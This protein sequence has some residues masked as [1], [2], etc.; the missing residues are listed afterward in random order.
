MVP[1]ETARL[2]DIATLRATRLPVVMPSAGTARLL[3]SALDLA[4][5]GT[6][7]PPELVAWSGWVVRCFD[8]ARLAGDGTAEF[9]LGAE[10]ELALWQRV[11]A[12]EDAPTQAAPLARDA[13][14]LAHAWRLSWSDAAPQNEDSLAFRRWARAYR[15]YTAELGATD[16]ARVPELLAAPVAGTALAHGFIAPA[17]ATAAW[18]GPGGSAPTA[19]P[20]TFRGVAYA[21][22]ASE[23]D[24][25]LAW[26]LERAQAE[27]A[28]RVVI[29]L[30]QLT[31]ERALVKRALRET[32][33]LAPA[34][35]VHTAVP[36]T[37]HSLPVMQSALAVIALEP[38][39]R[40][41][42]L[43]AV[44]L[45]PHTLGAA[46]EY[47]ARAAF[48]AGLR[49]GGHYERP[50]ADV[51]TLAAAAAGV[52]QL[53]RL[54]AA[55][56][57]AQAQAPRRQTLNGWRAHFES[58]LDAAGWPGELADARAARAAWIETGDRLQRLDTVLPAV[59][60]GEARA[61][62]RQLLEDTAVPQ[63]GGAAGIHLVTPEI[64]LALAPDHLWL[65]GAEVD[66]FNAPG[67]P[68]PLWSYAAQRAAGVPGADPARDLARAQYLVA[69]LAHGGGSRVASYCAGDGE[70]T[71][72]PSPLIPALA[73]LTAVPAR[74]AAPASWLPAEVTVENS[75]DSCGTPLTDPG[76]PLAGGVGALAAQAACPFR[77][78]ARHR[79]AA[80]A[81][82][83]PRPG[84]EA[85]VRGTFVHRVLA[86]VWSQLNSH[87]ALVALAP[88]E[89]TALLDSAIG[90]A[91]AD[92]Q[93]ATPLE[94]ALAALERTRLAAVVRAWLEFE[95]ARPPFTVRA[96]EQPAT[97]VYGGLTLRTRIDRLDRLADGR[98]RIV[99]YKT[100][101]C[102]A[103]AWQP[104][105][106]DEP[107]LPFYALTNPSRALA[108]IAFAKVAAREPGWIELPPA[109]TDAEQAA[110]IWQATCAAWADDLAVLADQLRRGVATVDPKRGGQTCRYCELSL[111]CRI[112]EAVDD[113]AE[114]DAADGEP[115]DAGMRAEPPS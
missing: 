68:S 1:A 47:A 62:L 60:R 7:E 29:A 114:R 31:R 21:D 71:F 89:L 34:L 8:A 80:T 15:A 37:L 93:F 17:P 112:A 13:W 103:S 102:R 87:A 96:V 30:P 106:L 41:D 113:G 65:A 32:L 97:V 111:L 56:V 57:A 74:R 53:A 64:A 18:L 82:D 50:L 45:S 5:G 75:I 100:G 79:L 90:R 11:L 10:Q 59:G 72:S 78:Y 22:R 23:L 85:K 26:A 94:R 12:A 14:R 52:P 3:Q 83:E 70:Q 58:C 69:L 66:A 104:P 4:R 43:S 98:E 92:W 36:E 6:W 27:P 101:P 81:V 109:D 35:N 61:R 108:G 40:W 39:P 115:M 54:L 48:D 49:A 2:V 44:I 38:V 76:T 77:A 84:L 24:A 16:V 28:A 73:G 20:G 107:Q 33:G 67:G 19:D 91:L 25:A 55:L 95:R 42:A 110:A 86:L 51:A 46:A 88:A 9:V 99:D 105:R 63:A